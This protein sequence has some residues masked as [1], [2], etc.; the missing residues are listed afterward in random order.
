M[1]ASAALIVLRTDLS[2]RCWQDTTPV[3][4]LKP[5]SV[6]SQ[7]KNERGCNVTADMLNDIGTQLSRNQFSLFR[8]G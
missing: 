8:H 5:Y 4:N 7:F 1:Q 6:L 3:V 2:G